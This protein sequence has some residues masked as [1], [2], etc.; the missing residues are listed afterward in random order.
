MS[1]YRRR[2]P[3]WQPE[4][5]S[6]FLTWKL[7]G[8]FSQGPEGDPALS[9]GER[10]VLFGR[11]LDLARTGPMWL[12]DERIAACVADAFFRGEREWKLY[13]LFAWVILSNH[14]HLLVQPHRELAQLTRA[15]KSSSAREANLIL[16]RSGK[17]FWQVESYDH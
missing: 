6:I 16:H 7:Y 13:E 5:A 11:Q 4:G 17:P 15:I 2:L 8:Y 14:V 3:H 1:F 12:Q 9:D 10:F